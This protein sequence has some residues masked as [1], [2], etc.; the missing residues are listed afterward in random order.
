MLFCLL[1]VMK[2]QIIIIIKH[3]IDLND[4]SHTSFRLWTCQKMEGWMMVGVGVVMGMC[5]HI[6]TCGGG[7]LLL[8]GGRG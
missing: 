6:V 3:T 8:D 7:G 5:C 4:V 2:K 1:V